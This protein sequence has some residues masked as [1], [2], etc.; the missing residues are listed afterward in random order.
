[1]SA[2][3]NPMAKKIASKVSG[4]PPKKLPAPSKKASAAKTGSAPA[5]DKVCAAALEKLRELNLDIGLQG[6]I[7][8][9][10]AS[11]ANDGN[12][13]GLYLMA[14]RALKQ[15]NDV[16]GPQRKALPAK[17]MADLTKVAR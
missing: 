2:N 16:K 3:S 4:T 12:P 11:Y 17:L 1:L 9:C 14:G 10:L 6:E 15:F 8:W 7:Q 13:I 5:V